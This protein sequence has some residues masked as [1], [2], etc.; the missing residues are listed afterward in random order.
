MKQKTHVHSF[1]C[2]FDADL[3]NANFTNKGCIEIRKSIKVLKMGCNNGMPEKRTP[4]PG[5]WSLKES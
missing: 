3:N 1:I 2:I 4:S 5:L